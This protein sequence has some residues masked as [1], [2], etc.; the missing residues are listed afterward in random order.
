M[1]SP[2][3]SPALTTALRPAQGRAE[4]A[5]TPVTGG[6]LGGCDV[7]RLGS[8]VRL[9]AQ[10]GRVFQYEDDGPAVTAGA[11]W[12]ADLLPPDNSPPV[13]RV[14]IIGGGALARAC[15]VALAEWGH[16]LWLCDTGEPDRHLHPHTHH[17]TGQA[18]LAEWLTHTERCEPGQVQV[19][20][21][22]TEIS[23]FSQQDVVVVAGNQ[24]VTDRAVTTHLL[25]HAIP[26]LTAVQH[27]TR[28]VISSV[29]LPGLTACQCC[30]DLA[31]ADGDPLWPQTVEVLAARR[32]RVDLGL[33]SWAGQQV[34]QSVHRHFCG[35]PRSNQVEGF[36]DGSVRTSRWPLH[37]DCPCQL[38]GTLVPGA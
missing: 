31:L 32:A 38:T 34:V 18:A 3:S 17:T 26:H 27:G 16:Q 21:H 13:L 11:G 1:T 15:A 35:E 33:C 24:A 28:A 22:W 4:P 5:R 9:L 10:D 29:T 12:E 36:G 8:V 20:D 19:G 6:G 37:P 25:R 30:R 7:V 2:A 23:Q 14:A